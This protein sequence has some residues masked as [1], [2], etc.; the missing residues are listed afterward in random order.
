MKLLG[1]R[2]QQKRRKI[3]KLDITIAWKRMVSCSNCCV[4]FSYKCIALDSSPPRNSAVAVLVGRLNLF[5]SRSPHFLG[6]H[7]Q[8]TLSHS[9][10]ISATA[11]IFKLVIETKFT[12]I[13]YLPSSGSVA[14]RMMQKGRL[15]NRHEIKPWL[16]FLKSEATSS[17]ATVM[18]FMP[19][20]WTSFSSGA[21]IRTAGVN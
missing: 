21:V 10:S 5:Q 6:T 11:F 4:D 15:Y 19:F 14:H 17:I 16:V 7:F 9:E 20:C 2:Q 12:F 1:R 13:W 18:V 3:I 8:N